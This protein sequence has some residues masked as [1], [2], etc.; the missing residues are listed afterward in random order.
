MEKFTYLVKKKRMSFVEQKETCSFVVKS[1]TKE[2]FYLLILS[3]KL[4]GRAGIHNIGNVF[5]S[6][7]VFSPCC[8]YFPYIAD[9]IKE[10]MKIGSHTITFTLPPTFSNLVHIKE[11]CNVGGIQPPIRRETDLF[12]AVRI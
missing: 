10:N 9:V 8:S 5:S 4:N 6:P 2:V 3:I 12:H 1:D 7:V 11:N